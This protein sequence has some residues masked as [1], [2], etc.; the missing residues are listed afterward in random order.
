M[1]AAGIRPCSGDFS[2]L[3][4]YG[5][6][7][8][9][10]N[11][12]SGV[13]VDG[14][15]WYN[16]YIPANLVNRVNSAGVCTGVCGVPSSYKPISSP[17]FPTPA[18]GGNRNDPAFNFYE[19]NTVFVKLKDGSTIQTAMNT[20]LNPLRNQY[21]L[22]PFSYTQGANLFKNFPIREA[23]R[24]RVEMN[25]ANVFNAQGLNQPATYGIS[26]LQTSAKAAR[27]VTLGFRLYW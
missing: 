13:C 8:P 4:T 15:L 16:A 26:S 1:A 19:T 23:V 5:K 6:D 21:F 22:G 9:V 18:D 10:K 7:T 14:Y 17:I 24:L 12:T 3:Q 2:P 11:C 25:F 20:G 27:A